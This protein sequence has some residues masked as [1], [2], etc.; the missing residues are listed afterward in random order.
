MRLNDFQEDALSTAFFTGGEHIHPFAYLSIGLSEESGEVAGKIK[1]LF[2]D[3]SG[4]LT[5]ITKKAIGNELGD[6]FWYLAV[7]ADKIGYTLEDIAY[8]NIQKRTDRKM[9]NT[10]KGEGDDR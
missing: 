5:P 9:R 4:E 7:L 10:Q 3:H 8:L 1:K 2:R 6:T